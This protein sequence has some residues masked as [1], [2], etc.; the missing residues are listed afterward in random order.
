MPSPKTLNSTKYVHSSCDVCGRNLLR[1]ESADTY[2]AG[3]V[4]RQVCDLCAPRALHSGWVREDESLKLVTGPRRPRRRSLWERLRGQRDHDGDHGRSV[5]RSAEASSAP[6][7]ESEQLGSLKQE[8]ERSRSLATGKAMSALDRA[9]AT[10]NASEFPRSVAGITRSLGLPE[11]TVRETADSIEVDV[12][13][14]WELSWYH[15][16]VDLSSE[17]GVVE[18]RDRGTELE[19]LGPL[20][21]NAACDELGN[22]VLTGE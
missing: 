5:G 18:L 16:V 13:I 20:I 14:A 1:G 2:I 19:Q 3:G 7:V 22:L 15:Y 12:L 11:V 17:V 9:V 4:R 10:F 8:I 21:V 6:E